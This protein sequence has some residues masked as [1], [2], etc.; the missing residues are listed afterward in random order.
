MPDVDPFVFDIRYALKHQPVSASTKK[1]I[2]SL[3]ATELDYLC[4]AIAAHLLRCRWAQHPPE[5][6][7]TTEQYPRSGT[8]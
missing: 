6:M 7:A 2:R 4:G 3:T 8:E 5:P 1:F